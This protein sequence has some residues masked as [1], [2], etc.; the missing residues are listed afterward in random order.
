MYLTCDE[1]TESII[2]KY[3]K[4]NPNYGKGKW[5][6]SMIIQHAK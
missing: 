2:G 4:I 6:Q 1:R 5:T 3:D